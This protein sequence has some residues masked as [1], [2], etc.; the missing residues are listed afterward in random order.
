[1]VSQVCEAKKELKRDW[2]VLKKEARVLD[3]LKCAYLLHVF[4]SSQVEESGL[5]WEIC[6]EKGFM[7]PH[8][9]ILL[10]GG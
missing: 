6:L 9:L 8:I 2:Q 1:M 3:P 10:T 4:G 5:I 7:Q